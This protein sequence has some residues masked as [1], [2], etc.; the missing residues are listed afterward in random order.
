MRQV[1]LLVT[2]SASEDLSAQRVASLVQPL[3]DCGYEDALDAPQ[4]YDDTVTE[5][6][7]SMEDIKV[8]HVNEDH[9]V[10]G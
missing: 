9:H 7:L 2:V 8:T 1:R 6:V 4:Q 5:L 10:H 3:I